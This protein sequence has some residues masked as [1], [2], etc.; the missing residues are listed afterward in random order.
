M[1]NL[2]PG[3]GVQAVLPEAK[4]SHNFC[5]S[6]APPGSL[7]LIPIRA[8]GSIPVDSGGVLSP[9]VDHGDVDEV[10][11]PVVPSIFVSPFVMSA[12]FVNRSRPRR[13]SE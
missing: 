5:G 3:P 7:Q 4:L 12:I 13:Q 1:L 6:E 9:S 11:L 10:S 2:C 8:I